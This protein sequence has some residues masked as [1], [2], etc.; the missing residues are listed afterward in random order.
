MSKRK[1]VLT[2]AANYIPV[3]FAAI[4]YEAGAI[5]W[6]MFLPLHILLLALNNHISPNRKTLL[7]LSANLLVSTFA[8]HKLCWYLYAKFVCNDIVGAALAWGGAVI[9][10]AIV[11]ISSLIMLILKKKPS[12]S[13]DSDP[14]ET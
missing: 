1:L 13:S 3:I 8:A 2:I 10:L 7:L 5:L 6:L 9:G 4:C 12:P 11:S 14:S